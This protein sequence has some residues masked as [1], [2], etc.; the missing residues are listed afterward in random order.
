MRDKFVKIICL[1]L[2]I[3]FLVMAIFGVKNTLYIINNGTKTTATVTK[4]I[5]GGRNFS[6]TELIK[7][8]T[9]NGL[10]VNAKIRPDGLY[11]D[12]VGSNISIIYNSEKVTETNYTD[13]SG[14]DGTNPYLVEVDSF[15]Y[16]FEMPV[17]L[18]VIG[19]LFIFVIPKYLNRPKN[20]SS[21]V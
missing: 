20:T 5:L 16:L 13:L 8:T 12:P 3:L 1:A 2:S 18:L 4:C 15:E 11:C 9:F 19:L 14:N 6:D 21:K 10:D 17:G 7:F